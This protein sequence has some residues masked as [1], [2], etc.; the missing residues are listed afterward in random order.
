MSQYSSSMF[1]FPDVA[2][3]AEF[4]L[5]RAD[6]AA[7]KG[8]DLTITTLGG[9]LGVTEYKAA[10]KGICGFAGSRRNRQKV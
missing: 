3:A 10:I 2:G 4:V 6:A 1:Q 5:S 9:L 8:R 7:A